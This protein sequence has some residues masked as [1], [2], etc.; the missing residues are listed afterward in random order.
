[1]V[2]MMSAAESGSCHT[3]AKLGAPTGEMSKCLLVPGKLPDHGPPQRRAFSLA[4][5]LVVVAV[6]AVLALLLPVLF[7]SRPAGAAPGI[8][9]VYNL[10][11]L[12]IGWYI[13]P[14]DNGDR[15]VAT[16]G[17]G[18]TATN[19]KDSR[20]TNG[21]WV[22]G[23]MSQNP[24]AMDT[25]LIIAGSLF[26]YVKNVR[27]YRCPADKKSYNGVLTTRSVSM[28]AFMN[29]V[30]VSSKGPFVMRKIADISNPGPAKCWVM[31][32]E[33]PD[34]IND[35][36]FVCDLA[37]ENSNVWVDRPAAYHNQAAGLIFADGHAEIHK[38]TDP[39]VLQQSGGGSKSALQSPPTD[40][41]W[42][43]ARTTH[44]VK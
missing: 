34:S 43:Q 21:I 44:M 13:Y 8:R 4:E 7:K 19:L 25:N 37:P 18:D 3:H 23:D 24:S 35:G 2:S 10:H 33:N 41:K 16:G 1:M 42:L 15:L 20:I 39:A 40:L 28:N 38:W 27:I 32:D 30:T 12:M 9:C 22:H 26:P 36:S 29:P 5:L 6:I 17:I 31:I 11:Q 14:L